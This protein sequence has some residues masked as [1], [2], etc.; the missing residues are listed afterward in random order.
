MSDTLQFV[1]VKRDGL[2]EMLLE[3]FAAQ[4]QTEVCGRFAR[5]TPGTLTRSSAL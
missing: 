3:S 5:Y 2:A 4:R 1:V